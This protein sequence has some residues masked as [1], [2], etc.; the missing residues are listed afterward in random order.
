MLKNK[1]N[2]GLCR[3]LGKILCW[4]GLWSH[5]LQWG[6]APLWGTSRSRWQEGVEGDKTLARELAVGV[7]G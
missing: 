3:A 2:S 7:C 4:R 1:V 5:S 6:A